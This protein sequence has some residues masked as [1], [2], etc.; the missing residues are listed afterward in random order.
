MSDPN[1]YEPP[2]AEINRPPTPGGAPSAACPKCQ[3]TLARK[4][5]FTWWGGALG[6]RLFSVVQCT[7]C[8]TRYNGKTGGRLTGVIVVYQLVIFV[9]AAVAFGFWFAHR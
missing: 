4:V 9:I 8:G 3:N 6:P 7:Q 1:A 2:R 5:G